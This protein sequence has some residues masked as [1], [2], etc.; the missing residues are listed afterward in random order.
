MLIGNRDGV[1]TK[2]KW[3]FAYQRLLKPSGLVAYDL[4]ASGGT[5]VKEIWRYEKSFVG[6]VPSPLLHSGLIYFV[7]NGG[8]FTAMDAATGQVAKAGRLPQAP[9]SYYA[10]PVVTTDGRIFVVSDKGKV[11]VVKAGRDWEVL[12]V[13]DLEEDSYATPAFSDGKIYF[14]TNEA[15]YCFGAR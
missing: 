3:D 8:I 5:A 9:D 7:K 15:M 10:S 13:N 1:V 14:R 4:P 6:V 2:E 11:S 12:T